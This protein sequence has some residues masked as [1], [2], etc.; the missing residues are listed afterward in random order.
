MQSV[1]Q[2]FGLT[3]DR[4]LAWC[5]A[6]NSLPR[7]QAACADMAV[8]MVVGDVQF[9]ADDALPCMAHPW[10][11]IA[12]ID[13]ETWVE[14]LLAAGKGM[15]ID[16]GS[17]ESVEPTLEFLQRQ[18]PEVPVILHAN[19]FTLLNGEGTHDTLEP[20]QFMRLCQTYVP[21]ALISLGWSLK[22]EADADG[23]MEEVLI[24]QMADMTLK[25]LG[26]SGYTIDIRAGYTSTGLGEIERGAAM[27]F[28]PIPTPPPAQTDG[29][30]GI[31]A[32]GNVLQAGHLFRRVA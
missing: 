14:A 7:L 8:H 21:H 5:H 13:L 25:R 32:D 29:L 3:D 27:I 16:F 4:D 9:A 17:A 31:V 24:S 20:E 28:E 10:Q 6:V 23:R 12:D 1:A 11:D 2:Y 15:K 22:R 19:I 30:T 18:K 26:A